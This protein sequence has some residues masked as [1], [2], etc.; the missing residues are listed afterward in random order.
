MKKK[1][2]PYLF[3]G[4]LVVGSSLLSG[5]FAAPPAVYGPPPMETFLP[6]YNIS[7]EVYGPPPEP[8]YGPPLDF[9]PEI[10]LPTPSF[11]P[12]DNLPAPMY[13]PPPGSDK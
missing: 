13:G 2:V 8:V 9:D 4:G 10:A 7:E 12:G 1:R 6:E 5:C 11:D 3:A